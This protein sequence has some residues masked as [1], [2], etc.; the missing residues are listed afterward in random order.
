MFLF[1][2]VDN[3]AHVKPDENVL[4]VQ[5]TKDEGFML[6]IQRFGGM[7]IAEGGELL[8]E[9]NHAMFSTSVT[10]LVAPDGKTLDH[11]KN[12]PHVDGSVEASPCTVA[13]IGPSTAEHDRVT[14][15]IVAWIAQNK[16]NLV[17]N[18]LDGVARVAARG[19]DKVSK[20]HGRCVGILPN[21]LRRRLRSKT[22][23]VYVDVPVYVPPGPVGTHIL[24]SSV[25]VMVLVCPSEALLKDLAAITTFN[26]PCI[27]YPSEESCTTLATWGGMFKHARV[28]RS[29]DDLLLY[30]DA[31]CCQCSGAM[32]GD[33]P[34]GETPPRDDD[35]ARPPAQTVSSTDDA[36]DDG[37]SVQSDGLNVFQWRSL[38][39]RI[40]L[41]WLKDVQ[42]GRDLHSH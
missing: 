25:D 24:T 35:I 14:E 21:T 9:V 36:G 37:S 1:A 33:R 6:D 28:T 2:G 41:R 39:T 15:F 16:H 27:V 26:V 8:S 30:M 4:D 19:F 3:E 34:E 7:L 11:K 23:D 13:V 5:P 12:L 22:E 38:R 10:D 18:G 42:D 40:A 32:Y 31:A 20:R 29:A 17:V